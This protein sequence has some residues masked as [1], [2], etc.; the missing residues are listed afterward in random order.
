[1]IKELCIIGHPSKIGGADTELD[2]QIRCWQKMGITVHIC[3][4]SY[5]DN[6]C[7]KMKMEERDCIYHISE[8]WKSLTGMHTISFCN[9]EFL[10]NLIKIK[11]YAKTTTFVNCMTWNFKKEIE[12]KERGLI[13]F[14]LYQTKEQFE[15]VSKK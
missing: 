14:H 3:H 2:H 8:D 11:K 1:M 13:D 12:A 7:K 10:K 4:T 5:V 6:N 9:G 15:K